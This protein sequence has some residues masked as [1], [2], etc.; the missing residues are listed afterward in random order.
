MWDSKLKKIF[1]YSKT[2]A[3]Q[4]LNADSP[5]AAVSVFS[6]EGTERSSDLP[7]RSKMMWTSFSAEMT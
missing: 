7:L 6:S 2:S 5:S 4:Q 1:H 3:G